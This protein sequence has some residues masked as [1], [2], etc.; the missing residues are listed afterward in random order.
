MT[1][2]LLSLDI[3]KSQVKFIDESTYACTESFTKDVHKMCAVMTQQDARDTCEEVANTTMLS[4][5]LC[6]IHQALSE[7][8]CDMDIQFGGEDQVRK[9]TNPISHW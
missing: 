4:P 3:P 5:M 8:Y 9:L 6:A 7:E 2:I 1:A